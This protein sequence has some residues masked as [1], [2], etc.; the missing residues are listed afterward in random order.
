LPKFAAT[1]GQIGDGGTAAL[2]NQDS[3]KTA[4]API[5]ADPCAPRLDVLDE[6]M[7]RR[8]LEARKMVRAAL[9]PEARQQID[10]F[11]ARCYIASFQD[12]VLCGE[13]V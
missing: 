5:Q 8:I 3:A 2:S 7:Q 4:F 13:I 12:I 6:P 9:S 1:L 11:D 10:L